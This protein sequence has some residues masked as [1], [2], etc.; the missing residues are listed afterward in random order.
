VRFAFRESSADLSGFSDFFRAFF[1]GATGSTG[2][3]SASGGAGVDYEPLFGGLGG[4]SGA[5]YAASGFGT[6]SPR[7]TRRAAARA[8]ADASADATISLE[9]VLR[10]TER[11]LEVSGKRLEVKIPP[12]VA[13]GQRIRLSGKAEGGGN[14]YITVHVARHEV[15]TRDAADLVMELPLTLGEA[16]LGAQVS[17]EALGGRKLLLTIP[18]ATQ[19]GR[20]FRLK[21]QGL[22][23]FG[24]GAPGDL[25]VRTSVVLPD[26]LDEAG[27]QKARAL[28]DHIGQADPRPR[29]A[30]RT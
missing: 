7:G 9:E 15:F 29:A 12:G 1:G 11:Q 4:D 19:N 5:G 28:V 30:A 3:G 23:R 6:G 16:L 2:R 20:V 25:R 26:Q 18:A 14:V 24:G 27:L 13:N 17:I 21:G 10:G 22:P 8:P